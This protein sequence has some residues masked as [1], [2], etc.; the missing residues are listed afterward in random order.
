MTDKGVGLRRDQSGTR[1][2]AV[3]LHPSRDQAR[4]AWEEYLRGGLESLV[5][6]WQIR[7][8]G[9]LPADPRCKVRRAPFRGVG[10]PLVRLFGLPPVRPSSMNPT[11]CDW[12]ESTVKR[13]E[14]GA[15]VE[16]TLLFADVR[17]STT[18]AEQVGPSE[19]QRLIDRFYRAST[20]ILIETDALVD[21]L[22]GDEIIALY[23]PG[24]A[25]PDHP[26]RAL[27]AA[28][29]LL[30]ATGHEAESEPWLPIG[31]GIHSGTA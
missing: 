10:R 23:V 1:D 8:M 2:S 9:L 7:T 4:A 11:L 17:G 24:I 19:F 28:Y 14:V 30:A 18:L 20:E 22:V 12:C 29:R 6:P 3:I 13:H 21:K 5:M 27:D 31:A 26:R 16:L 15:E 25:G